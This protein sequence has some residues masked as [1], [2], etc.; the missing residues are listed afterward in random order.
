MKKVLKNVIITSLLGLVLF[1][2]LQLLWALIGALVPNQTLRAWIV[3]LVT[4]GGYA[5]LLAFFVHAKGGR[6]REVLEDYK[7]VGYEGI[8]TDIKRVWK[9]DAIYVYVICAII[10]ICYVL[11][12][13]DGLLFER[14]VLSLPA[15]IFVSLNIISGCFDIKI[16]GY[17]VAALY[18][19]VS[20]LLCV[21]IY[22]RK[23]YKKWT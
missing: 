14:S 18:V 11:S 9:R 13:I 10:A 6:D 12:T 3:A 16:L 4:S 20:Y 15:V 22:R 21:L 23:Q 17:I 1:I 2:A 8:L 5:V 19:C 7:D